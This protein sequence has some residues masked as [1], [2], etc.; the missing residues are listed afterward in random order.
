LVVQPVA[1]R[2]TDYDILVL[3]LEVFS[4]KIKVL[5]VGL[6]GLVAKTKYL[7]VNRQS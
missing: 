1:S 6:K 7:A 3:Q 2:Y 4:W 5:V